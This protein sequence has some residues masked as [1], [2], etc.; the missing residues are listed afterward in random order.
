MFIYAKISSIRLDV[1]SLFLIKKFLNLL[2]VFA[3]FLLAN[4]C[5]AEENSLSDFED[6]GIDEEL[7]PARDYEMQREDYY[8]NQKNDN[9]SKIEKK[10]QI[11]YEVDE[12]ESGSEGGGIKFKLDEPF[13]L[14]LAEPDVSP[15][16]EE[17]QSFLNLFREGGYQFKEGIVKNQRFT[18][19]FHG[20]D[21][22]TAQRGKEVSSTFDSVASEFQ[23]STV[24]RNGKTRFD[25]GLNFT[26]PRKYND[27]LLTKFSYAEL[28]HIFNENQKMVIG[29]CRTQNGYE[30]GASSSQLKFV[31][32]S[33][34]ARTFGN[35][36][37]DNIRNRGK[38]KYFEYDLGISDGSRYWQNVFNGF[39]TTLLASAK[40]LAK[41][42]NNKYGK[43]KVGGSIDQGQAEST[44]WTVVGGHALYDY[45]NKFGLDFEYQYADG[46][47]GS[48]YSKEKAHGLYA[49]AYYFVT[50]RVQVLARYDYFKNFDTEKQNIEY[51]AGVN[52]WFAKRGKVMLNY[53][54]AKAN[55]CPQP[56]HKIYIG[57]DFTTYSV[58]DAIFEHL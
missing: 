12:N 49:T 7:F 44:T 5:F 27:H 21:I 11:K 1:M 36:I 20:G 37:S 45:K 32:R 51:T 18:F 39:N 26:R 48:W 28:W 38:Y 46:Y 13:E 57:A 9:I 56:S 19:Y 22:M 40:P 23:S 55:T 50:P 42:E 3:I 25:W 33:Q 41:F 10:F 47:A 34:I 24:F 58:L 35:A 17:K 30:G 16:Q 2:C 29:N 52:Y 8:L 31:A 53:V 14:K 54:L 6:I 43:L 4:P 15:F